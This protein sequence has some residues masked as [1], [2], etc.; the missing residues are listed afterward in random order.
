MEQGGGYGV[1][2]IYIHTEQG[3]NPVVSCHGDH[4]LSHVVIYSGMNT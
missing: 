1:D 4:L 2:H 3:G